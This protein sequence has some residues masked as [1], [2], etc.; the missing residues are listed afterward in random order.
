LGLGFFPRKAIN[1]R[2]PGGERLFFFFP[3]LIFLC[4]CAAVSPVMDSRPGKIIPEVPFFPQEIY[5]CGPASLAGVLN[6]WRISVTP[7]EIAQAIYSPSAR[8][9][10]DLDLVFY[11]EKKG[12]K[13]TQYAG[14]VEDIKKNIDGQVPLIVLVDEGFLVYQKHHFMVVVGYG[15]AGLLANSGRERHRFYAWPDFLKTWE[16]TKNW[17]LR[18]TPR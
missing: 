9:T 1:G 15:D 3:L 4:S 12:L 17:T 10:L 8:G 11:G 6:Y 2:F 18:L 14:S 7:E 13:A 5:Q 16:K